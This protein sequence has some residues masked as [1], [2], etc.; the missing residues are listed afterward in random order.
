M[1]A[2]EL[3]IREMFYDYIPGWNSYDYVIAL[4]EIAL[5]LVLIGFAFKSN[6][7]FTHKFLET[8]TRCAL[9]GMFIAASL[10]KLDSPQDFAFLVA[11]Y[12]FLPDFLVNIFALFLPPLEFITGIMLIAGTRTRENATILF[13]M[14]IAFIIALIWALAK[15][16]GITCGCFGMEGAND[17]KG[18]WVTLIRDVLLLAP[19]LYLMKYSK[20]KSL[21]YLWWQK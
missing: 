12:Q 3:N 16:L 6:K 4:I 2:E 13:W 20:N 14:F 21:I 1:S 17:K 15:D 18:A 9:G 8:Y 7:D 11:Q 10:F 5:A 19:C